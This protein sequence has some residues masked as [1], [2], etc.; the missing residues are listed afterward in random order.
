MTEDQAKRRFL[1]L[2]L[3]R[4]IAMATVLFGVVI[5][6]GKTRAD[7]SVGYLI[8]V[9][10]AINFFIIPRWLKKAWQAHGQEPEQ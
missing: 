6:A 2:S 7:P 10:G 1:V 3:M 4:A 8:F 5:I 9:I